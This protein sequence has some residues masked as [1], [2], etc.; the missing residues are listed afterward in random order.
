MSMGSTGWCKSAELFTVANRD[1]GR[2]SP[3]RTLGKVYIPNLF[4]GLC[5]DCGVICAKKLV[6]WKELSTPHQKIQ[7]N[8]EECN[9]NPYFSG[10]AVVKAKTKKTCKKQCFSPL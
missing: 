3:K 8:S 6:I 7:K 4:S 10:T 2:V 5:C 9:S 1:P